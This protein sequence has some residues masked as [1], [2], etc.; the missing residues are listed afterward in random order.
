[1]VANVNISREEMYKE[2]KPYGLI[3]IVGLLIYLSFSLSID[4]ISTFSKLSI[5][6]ISV[7]GFENGITH[8]LTAII[9]ITGFISIYGV[10]KGSKIGWYFMVGLT[11]YFLLMPVIGLT[12]DLIQLPITI[13]Q[14]GFEGVKTNM[15]MSQIIRITL[16][17]LCVIYFHKKNVMW[18]LDMQSTKMSKRVV[19]I[20]IPVSIVLI[21]TS[22]ISPLM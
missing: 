14:Y 16:G 5:S 1:M 17:S 13:L 9:A 10:F 3:P 15:I 4:L 2:S 11:S 7:L 19:I 6:Q 20:L 21:I 12:M 18:Y 8:F 22:M